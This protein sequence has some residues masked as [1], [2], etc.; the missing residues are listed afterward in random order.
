M[1]NYEVVSRH[2]AAI[3]ANSPV[4]YLTRTGKK[5]HTAAHYSNRTRS[6]PLSYA[7]KTYSPCLVCRP[8]LPMILPDE[9]AEPKK[10]IEYLLLLAILSLVFVP[11]RSTSV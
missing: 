7:Q 8:P 4:V 11:M 3:R 5:Y 6:A 1:R 10:S 2:E 9:P